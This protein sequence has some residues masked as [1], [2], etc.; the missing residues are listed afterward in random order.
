[1]R[2]SQACLIRKWKFGMLN[3]VSIAEFSVLMGLMNMLAGRFDDIDP[4][5]PIDGRLFFRC[6]MPGICSGFFALGV[7]HAW[8]WAIYTWA[9][10]TAGSALWFAPGW[11]FDEI[12]GGWS[13]N[14][15]P[16]FMR[17]FALWLIPNISDPARNRA[18]G[19]LLKAIRGLYDVVTFAALYAINPAAPFNLLGS[20]L[21]GPI[22]WL[23]GQI[24]PNGAPVCDAEFWEGCLRG[25]LI[26]SAIAGGI[27]PWL[28]Q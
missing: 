13:P 11:S 18:R 2:G 20:I 19:T 4:H 24:F 23:M 22:Y 27:L 8:Y 12:T 3:A 17:R 5:F 26:G 10:V 21:M 15:Y 6:I 1:M 14:K 28:T 9:G 7:G 16:A 25:I